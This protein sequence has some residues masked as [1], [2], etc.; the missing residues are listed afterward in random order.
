[1]TRGAPPPGAAVCDVLV[2]GAG[3][4]GAVVAARL[5]E[6]PARQVWLVEA[7]DWPDDPDIADPRQWL[8]LAGRSHD[9]AYRTVPQP[10]TAGRVHE[11]PRGRVVGGS[12]CLHAMA[13]V[14]GHPLDF[15]PWQAIAGDG[16]GFAALAPGFRRS[17]RLLG[18][19]RDD[20]DGPL[21]VW[22]PEAEVSP[23]VRD[24]MAAGM[25][26]GAPAL[27][28][29]NAGR[30]IG[31]TANSLNIRDGLRQSVADAYLTAAVRARPNLRIL[32]GRMAV[33]IEFEGARAT[34][35]VFAGPEGAE[36]IVAGQTVLCAGAVASPLLLMRSG[37]GPSEALAPAGLACRADL[38]GVGRNLQDHLLVF[39]N[40]YRSRRPVPPS[41]LQHS[42]SLMY[43]DSTDLSACEGQ[44]DVVL[45]CVVAPAVLPGLAAPPPGEAF[46]ILC[47]PCRPEARGRILPTGPSPEDPP[48]IDPNY[49]DIEV[50][51][52]RLR[53]ALRLARAVGGHPA[54]ASWRAE[55][56]L[57]G[58]AVQD[59]AALDAFLARTASTHH[60]P[61][62]TCRMGQDAAA[63]VDEDLR[64]RGHEGLF[65]V[66]ASVMPTLPSGPINAAVVAIAETWAA[67][68]S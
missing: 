4:A 17:R 22:Q 12:G 36:S 27:A 19:G 66:D 57:P 35:A 43:L 48:H 61:A 6:D 28:H 51:R 41:R 18:P 68:Q 62:G 24:F 46:T 31:A 23:L 54:L 13:Y 50:D 20:G 33:R 67:R 9:W 65:V 47:G 60:H 5:S 15:A 25:D 11:W 1:M 59:D 37:I 44:P 42:E 53:R 26:L 14:Q 39:G 45:A 21:D 38:P 55:E 3:S 10:G 30:L 7:G 34:G 64:L 63:V 8:A 29:H 16:W 58:P 32:T 40:L 52:R 2:I 49:L 56:M